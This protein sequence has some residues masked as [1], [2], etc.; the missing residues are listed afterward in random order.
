MMFLVGL[1]LMLLVLRDVFHSV[2]PRGMSTRFCFAPLLVHKILWPP[3]FSI[4]SR[5]SSPT[6]KAEVLSLFAP[7]ALLLLL[8]AWICLL[9]GAFGLMSLSLSSHYS[10]PVNSFL[11]AFYV[12]ATSF[13]TLGIAPD[14]VPRL[15]DVKFLMLGGALAGMLLTASAVSLMIGLIAAIQPREALVSVTSN[16]GGSPPS[17]IAILETYSR[18]RGRESLPEFFKECHFWCADVLETH[19][20]YPILPYFRS[21]DPLTSWL[22]ALGAILDSIALLLS[23]D[24]DGHHFSARVTYLF[25][26]KLVNEF[27]AIYN[28]ASSKQ[29]EIN[30]EDFHQVYLR[31]QSAGYSANSEEA[32]RANF[33]LLQLRYLSALSALCDYLAVPGT[34]LTNENLAQLPTLTY[35]SSYERKK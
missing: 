3:F 13:L 1:L 12:S 16:L 5:V 34:A 25:G 29:T 19:K 10:P 9:A 8:I 2:V 6:L 7:C 31:L 33:R 18:M 4:A 17:G 27:A 21:N 11:S 23:V 15:N 20:A 35:A 24:P 26:C 32:A 22:T 14:F 30:D 28:I